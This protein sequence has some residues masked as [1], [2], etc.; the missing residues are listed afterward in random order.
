MD[1][2]RRLATTVFASASYP[3]ERVPGE[4][5][6]LFKEPN[7]ENLRTI[8]A[9]N[10]PVSLVGIHERTTHYPRFTI[11]VGSIGSVCTYKEFRGRGLATR[12]MN[13]CERRMRARGVDLVIVS[14]GRGL[15]RRLEYEPAGLERRYVVP[16]SGVE[17]A[18]LRIRDAVLSDVPAMLDLYRKLEVRFER[19][20]DDLG[21]ALTATLRQGRRHPRGA[22]VV[23]RGRSLVAYMS[24]TL[25]TEDGGL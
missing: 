3:P 20:E 24:F 8:V 5:P 9:G 4:Y 17:A 2:V 25:R 12:L 7:R 13:H 16:A 18:G 6:H 19:L 11:K 14:G 22:V 10:R 21:L 1:G 23:E 15:Y